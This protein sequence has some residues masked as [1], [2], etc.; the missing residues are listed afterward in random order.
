MN[1]A[2]AKQ[3]PFVIFAGEDEL[4]QNQVKVRN[5]LTGEETL[6]PL[7]PLDTLLGILHEKTTEKKTPKE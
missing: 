2:D 1:Y 7:A 5:M 6:V 4:S 3:I